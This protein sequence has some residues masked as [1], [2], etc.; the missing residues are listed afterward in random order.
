MNAG[1]D[2]VVFNYIQYVLLDINLAFI[3]VYFLCFIQLKFYF[4]LSQNKCLFWLYFIFQRHG[5]PQK[6]NLGRKLAHYSLWFTI[7]CGGKPV[8][9]PDWILCKNGKLNRWTSLQGLFSL[10]FSYLPGTLLKSLAHPERTLYILS[11]HTRCW[12]ICIRPE[13]Q[14]QTGQLR[15]PAL[16]CSR[17]QKDSCLKDS[18]GLFNKSVSL[19]C[20]PQVIF[21]TL[22][23]ENTIKH[24]HH[25]FQGDQSLFWALCCLV[26]KS[27]SKL[28]PFT[29]SG[30]THT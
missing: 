27:Q 25:S 30:Q 26:L 29:V 7:V 21:Q 5:H 12:W 10:Y 20:S 22:M 14:K 24:G 3:L 1:I 15:L 13:I 2:K 16:A 18:Q 17:N 9:V 19:M 8:F 11:L 28:F 23:K 4:E 6:L